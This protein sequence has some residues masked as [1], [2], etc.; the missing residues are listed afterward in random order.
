MPR[1]ALPSPADRER[2]RANQCEALAGVHP[3]E[4]RDQ[5]AALLTPGRSDPP[6]SPAGLDRRACA[7]A[8]LGGI[9]ARDPNLTRQTPAV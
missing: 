2:T 8:F 7:R 1:T 5:L 9:R 6:P 3:L 4:R